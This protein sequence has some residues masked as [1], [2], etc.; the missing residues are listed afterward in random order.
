MKHRLKALWAKTWLR[1]TLYVVIVIVILFV[2]FG[3]SKPVEYQT[4]LAGRGTI[5]EAVAATGQVRPKS[6]ASLRFKTT[7]SIARMNAEV[8]EQVAAGQA[9][10]I[11][12]TSAL[13]REV[14]K[15]QAE[16]V[17][18]QV[19][20]DNSGQEVTDTGVKNTQ[21]LDLLYAG[22]PS[23]IADIFNLSLQAYATLV[24][25]YESS[26]R[27]NSSISAS[28]QNAQL[29]VNAENAKSV[30]DEAKLALQKAVEDLPPS[31]SPAQVDAA[32][33]AAAPAL[34]KLKLSL[35]SLINVVASVPTG[36]IN[37]TTLQAYKDAL[38]TA[39]T[40]LNSAVTK[41]VELSSDISDAKVQGGLNTNTTNAALR[42]AQANVEKAK[43]TLAI[44]QQN[45]ADAY[46]RAPFSGTVAAKSK[47]VGE[48]VTTSDQVYY[49]IGEGGLEIT[50]NVPEVDIAKIKVGDKTTVKL[51]AYG[52]DTVFEA[53]VTDIDPAETIVDGVA[54]Y[55]VT[56]KFTAPDAGIRSGMTAELSIVT[57]QKQDVVK[58]PQQAVKLSDGQAVVR[59]ISGETA[60]DVPV[61]TG[62][63]GNDG[64]IEIV[65]GISDGA[66]VVVG[67]K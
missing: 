50:A 14:T 45:L 5:T 61:S 16:L 8:G 66:S 39:Q 59:V 27:L 44:A 54:T 51:D 52:N 9:L 57:A 67:T 28:S 2:L 58:V 56:F 26:G 17:V 18:A 33:S 30:A 34:Q 62:L 10:A 43:A 55:K 21:T 24:S 38:A 41:Q 15:A 31:A 42:T 4:V 36:S 23:T 29:V 48:L 25:F 46:L 3:G 13:S 37:A 49:L 22:A 65:G 19:A 63:R 64:M 32:L 20:L 40:N 6:Y 60:T 11:L 12:D 53:T 35:A 47:Q 1:R 7:G